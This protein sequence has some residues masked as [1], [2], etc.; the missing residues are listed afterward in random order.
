MMFFWVWVPCGLAGRSQ[1]FG[2][3]YC[4]HLQDWS[5]HAGN[6]TDYIGGKKEGLLGVS[7]LTQRQSLPYSVL[8]GPFLQT[9][10]PATLYNPSDSQYGHFSPEDGDSTLLRNVSIYQPVHMT[11]KPRRTSSISSLPWKSH[12]NANVFNHNRYNQLV[13]YDHKLYSSSY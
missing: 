1:C 8:I 11:P 7:P 4:L 12:I 3:V 2:E 10:L 5:D 6:Q 9:S 13:S